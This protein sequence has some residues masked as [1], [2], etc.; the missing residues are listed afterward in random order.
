MFIIQQPQKRL[1]IKSFVANIQNINQN[2]K[3]ETNVKYHH[4]FYIFNVG[5]NIMLFADIS[6]HFNTKKYLPLS[7]AVGIGLKI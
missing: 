7:Q 5:T 4:D 2:D 6:K 1:K 3:N